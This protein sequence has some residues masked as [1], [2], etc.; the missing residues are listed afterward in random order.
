MGD[1]IPIIEENP[2]IIRP[3]MKEV[4]IVLL[5]EKESYQTICGEVSEINEIDNI[6]ILTDK[7]KKHSFILNDGIL[8][9]KSKEQD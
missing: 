1:E 2:L 3:T 7:S 8:V 9:L 5:K 4:Y 6:L